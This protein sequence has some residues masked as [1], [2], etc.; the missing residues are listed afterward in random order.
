LFRQ[1]FPQH[2][3]GIGGLATPWRQESIS[4]TERRN[5]ATKILFDKPLTPWQSLGSDPIL[6]AGCSLRFTFLSP[7]LVPFFR[8]HHSTG[9]TKQKPNIFYPNTRVRGHGCDQHNNLEPSR[10]IKWCPLAFPLP[11]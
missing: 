9:E 5:L 3:V 11:P 7:L 6:L 10:M 4:Y 1:P 2:P 8:E